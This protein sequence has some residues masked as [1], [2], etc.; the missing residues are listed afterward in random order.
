MRSKKIIYGKYS[1]VEKYAIYNALIYAFIALNPFIR[2]ILG[3]EIFYAFC[4]ISTLVCV[5]K[6]KVSKNRIF[7]FIALIIYVAYITLPLFEGYTLRIGHLLWFIPL[8]VIIFYENKILYHSFLKLKNMLVFISAVSICVWIMTSIGINIPYIEFLREEGIRSNTYRL[9]GIVLAL[10]SH[11]NPVDTGLGGVERVCGVFAEPGAYAIILGLM[12]LFIKM[13]LKSTSNKILTVAGILTFSPVF[14]FIFIIGILSNYLYARKIN[15]SQIYILAS[16]LIVIFVSV[17]DT[18]IGKQVRFLVYERTFSNIKTN[19]ID[20]R[21]D[22][23]LMQYFNKFVSGG[24]LFTG[25]GYDELIRVRSTPNYRKYILAFGILGLILS[26][27][28]TLVIISTIPK[29]QYPI[30]IAVLLMIFAH[31]SWTML[32]PSVYTLLIIGRAYLVEERK[33]IVSPAGRANSYLLHGMKIKQ[34]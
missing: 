29:V 25:Y 26:V 6:L 23:A 2:W 19:P 10:Y 7:L 22:S 27:I 14:Y 32:L 15:R 1:P 30:F 16:V 33:T 8:F 34:V 12:L 5:P 17:T 4:I 9:Y 13:D 24:P 31:R 18:Y 28:L 21:V 20:D 3:T 11:G